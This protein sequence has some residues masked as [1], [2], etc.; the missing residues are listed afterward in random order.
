[1]TCLVTATIAQYCVLC[2]CIVCYGATDCH[3]YEYVTWQWKMSSKPRKAIVVLW[4]LQQET[5]PTIET[6]F[7]FYYPRLATCTIV[8]LCIDFFV[9]IVAI[10][11]SGMNFKH[12]K[13]TVSFL[14]IIF[15]TRLDVLKFIRKFRFWDSQL[16]NEKNATPFYRDNI[17]RDVSKPSEKTINQAYRYNKYLEIFEMVLHLRNI[18]QF[19]PFKR[20]KL[21]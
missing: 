9:Y 6:H 20:R 16:K 15:F 4:L 5:L 19:P 21:T 10:F 13:S 12:K 11:L 14:I 1:M 3:T 8:K 7:L 2:H 18:F 17:L